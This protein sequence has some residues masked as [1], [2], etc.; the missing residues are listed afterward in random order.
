MTNQEGDYKM[1]YLRLGIVALAILIT[2]I[3]LTVSGASNLIKLGGEVPDFNYESMKDIEEGDFV[4]GYVTFV[5]GSYASETTTNTRYG[6]ETSSY[7]SEDCFVIQLLND[8]DWENEML[9]TL[10]AEKKK[11][12]DVLYDLSDATWEYYGGNDYA[13]FPDM[14]VVAKVVELD[15]EY[16]GFLVEWLT[17]GFYEN[18][19]EARK[20]FYPYALKIFNPTSAYISLGVGLLILA[21]YAALGVVVY[22]K[23]RPGSNGAAFEA[24]MPEGN[25]FV[26][27]SAPEQSGFA[28]TYTPPSPVPMPDIP[29]P[30]QPDEFF[31]SPAPRTV[32]AEKPEPKK[33][34]TPAPVEAAAPVMGIPGNMDELDTSV[35]GLN[36]ADYYDEGDEEAENDSEFFE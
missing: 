5:L 3:V 7:T 35:L 20:H 1:V 29:Q 13:Y 26:K 34:E 18:A 4:Q 23:Y 31:S 19:S 14:G 6:I 32:A 24:A 8:E 2:G 30:V 10:I 16:E 22:K 17:D 21:A 9:I 12:W 28:E 33:E 25:D 11:D 27:P 15:D 36:D